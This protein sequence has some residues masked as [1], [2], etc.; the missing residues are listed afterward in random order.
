MKYY[1]ELTTQEKELIS[2]IQEVGYGQMEFVFIENGSAVFTADTQKVSNIK[3]SGNENLHVGSRP[4]GDFQLKHE[5]IALIKAIRK[6]TIGVIRKI[7]VRSGL[8]TDVIMA[9]GVMS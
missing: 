9:E 2:L 3:L 6:R 5:H 7:K 4:D 1:K 8:P